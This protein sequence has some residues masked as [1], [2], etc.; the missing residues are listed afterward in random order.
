LVTFAALLVGGLLLW[1]QLFLAKH[2]RRIFNP[3]LLAATV[4]TLIFVGYTNRAFRSEDHELKIAKQDAYDSIHALWQA[5]AVAYSANGDE[6]RALLDTAQAES[7]ARSFAERTA[8]IANPSQNTG[9]LADELKNITFAGEREAAEETLSRFQAYVAI[10]RQIRKLDQSG[11]HQAAIAL[12]IGNA[13]GQSNYAFARFDEA[14][15]RTLDIN[16]QAFDGAVSR[17]FADVS[18][19]EILAPVDALIIALLAL[20]GLLPRI[21]EYSA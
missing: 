8:R 7:Y 9:Y 20:F 11:Q 16:Q 14:L 10:D 6:S 12:C 15:G 5:R 19:F 21:R 2:M 13:R 18:G 1:L 17:G 3:L 4:L